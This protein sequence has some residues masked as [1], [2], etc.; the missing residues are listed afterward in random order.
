V[1]PEKEAEIRKQY[2]DSVADFQQRLK[3]AQDEWDAKETERVAWLQKLT[4]GDMNEIKHTLTEIFSGLH[5]PFKSETQCGLFFDAPDSVSVNLDLPDIE[6][7]ILSTRKRLLKN[8]ETRESARDESERNRDYFELVT[9]ECAFMAAE[10]F[11]YLP[12]CQS[13]RIAGY[14][15]R[16]RAREA[17]PIDTYI[18]DV[19]YKREELKNFN[20]DRTS[21]HSFLTD[22]G[23]RFIL[24]PN[25][26][27]AGID[28]P[29]WL[30]HDDVQN[31]AAE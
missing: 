11:S 10:T 18:L 24:T 9:G 20:P 27:F 14:A 26:K 2:D 1:W 22:L 15:K 4:A 28:P 7:V 29:S 13:I 5:L 21:M 3:A 17:D 19:K 8:G 12:L 6:E 30:K 25:N 31:A 23:A 16:P